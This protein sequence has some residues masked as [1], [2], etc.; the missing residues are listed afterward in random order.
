MRK[1]LL[2]FSL[3]IGL[4]LFVFASDRVFNF[5]GFVVNQNSQLERCL[6]S[7]PLESCLT[8][9]NQSLMENNIMTVWLLFLSI[10][11][12]VFTLV[13]I[14]LNPDKKQQIATS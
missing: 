5:S 7:T 13:L 8:V 10:A 2:V 6:S 3:V 9:I 14:S 11:V 1:I 4:A 12:P